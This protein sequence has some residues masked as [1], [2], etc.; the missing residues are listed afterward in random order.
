MKIS[1]FIPEHRG[2]LKLD[3][4][5]ANFV[6][7]AGSD[8]KWSD[9]QFEFSILGKII[10]CE[11]FFSHL[12]PYS[13][14]FHLLNAHQIVNSPIPPPAKWHCSRSPIAATCSHSA[15]RSNRSVHEKH[16]KHMSFEFEIRAPFKQVHACWCASNTWPCDQN[17]HREWSLLNDCI[18]NPFQKVSL[19]DQRFYA[20]TD[21][22]LAKG[23][24]KIYLR[25][26][27]KPSSSPESLWSGMKSNI[28]KSWNFQIVDK[29]YYHFGK[30][31]NLGIHDIRIKRMMNVCEKFRILIKLFNKCR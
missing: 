2:Y 29:N 31:G 18:T 10:N 27:V 4:F 7:L 30:S 8:A 24:V 9:P 28:M 21:N 13:S 11:R 1:L 17:P 23:N 16:Q 20:K 12:F 6:S 15:T 25:P 19:P 14:Q 22:I 5:N 26:K 3:I